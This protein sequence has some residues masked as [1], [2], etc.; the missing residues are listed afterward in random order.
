MRAVMEG[1]RRNLALLL[2]QHRISSQ[3]SCRRGV[4][5][6]KIHAAGSRSGGHEQPRRQL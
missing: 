5:P 3:E 1:S 4:E 6:A 2:L